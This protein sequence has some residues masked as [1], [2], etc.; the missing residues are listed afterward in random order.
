M[1]GCLDRLETV[2]TALSDAKAV[3]G[4]VIEH[5]E[6][7]PNLNAAE[8]AY[9]LGSEVPRLRSALSLVWDALDQQERAVDEAVSGCY[10]WW[11]KEKT[12]E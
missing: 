6:P 7:P 2:Q 11:R 3:V 4:L 8:A 1:K 9:V 5:L 10:E 12:K